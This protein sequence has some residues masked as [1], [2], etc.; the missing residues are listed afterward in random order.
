MPSDCITSNP[1]IW[2]SVSILTWLCLVAD[3]RLLIPVFLRILLP[4]PFLYP[5]SLFP[6]LPNA[7]LRRFG[8]TE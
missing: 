1:Q 5:F 8:T 3:S 7:G 6:V 4:F 2:V